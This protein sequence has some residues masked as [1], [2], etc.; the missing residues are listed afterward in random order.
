MSL[1]KSFLCLY[2]RLKT[3]EQTKNLVVKNDVIFINDCLISTEADYL[4]FYHTNLPLN[5][6]LKI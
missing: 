2:S 4:Q 1:Q 3:G 5:V 6:P